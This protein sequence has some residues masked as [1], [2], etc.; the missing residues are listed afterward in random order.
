[1][2]CLRNYPEA[3]RFMDKRGGINIFRRK[4]FVSK[5]QI[6]SPNKPSVLCFRK[7]PVAIK[8]F[9]KT[10]RGGEARFS[11]EKFLDNCAEN[12]RRGN[13]L[14]CVSEKLHWQ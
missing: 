6:S 3:K 4:F 14:C 7:T 5:C 13:L 10:V 9:D 8:F 2:L 12:T 1:M 11:V